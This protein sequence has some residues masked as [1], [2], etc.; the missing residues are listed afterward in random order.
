MGYASEHSKAELADFTKRTGIKINFVEYTYDK[1]VAALTANRPP[2]VVRGQGGLDAAYLWTKKIAEPL[3]PWIEK[4]KVLKKDDLGDI[5]NIWRF[6]GTKQGQ[7]D[8]MGLVKDYSSD[9]TIWV[10]KDLVP[11]VAAGDVLSYDKLHGLCLGAT[12]VVGGRV[13]TYGYDFYDVKPHIQWINTWCRS[14]GVEIFNDDMTQVDL[15]SADAVDAMQWMRD[16]VEAKATISDFSKS[17]VG[18]PDLFKAGRLAVFQSG[19]WTQGLWSDVKP[20][21][22]EKFLMLPAPQVGPKR[23]SPV[24]AGSGLFMT[25]T[26]KNKDAAW[27]FMED[28]FAGPPAKAR[29]SSGWGVPGLKSLLP[30]MPDKTALNKAADA[31]QREEDRHFSVLSFSPYAR[32]DGVLTAIQKT[33]DAGV[34]DKKDTAWICSSATSAI[35]DLLT[36]GKSR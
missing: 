21:M 27:A 13:Q 17:S 7:G 14:R 35:N 32:I 12:K 30:L 31:C 9:F 4:G 15:T 25:R 6:D 33:F 5:E 11:G 19:Y 16:L 3:D 24:L 34:K 10:N 26:S 1:L 20:A 2:D 29:A 22:A 28:Y 36:H 18:A 23:V 8:L